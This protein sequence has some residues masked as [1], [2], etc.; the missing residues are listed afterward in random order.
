MAHVRGAATEVQQIFFLK[1]DFCAKRSGAIVQ[2]K[3]L[4]CQKKVSSHSFI[5]NT[6]ANGAIIEDEQ[7]Q[8]N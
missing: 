1:S 4:Q 6:S 3:Q 5:T 7:L 2:D 8:S